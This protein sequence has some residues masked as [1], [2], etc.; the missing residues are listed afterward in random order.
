M[1]YESTLVHCCAPISVLVHFT[2]E[3][4]L[5]ASK[6]MS[7]RN[8]KTMN[9]VGRQ[10]ALPKVSSL[11][12]AARSCAASTRAVMTPDCQISKDSF[13]LFLYLPLLKPLC[14][15]Y[16]FHLF[17]MTVFSW[18]SIV[19][20]TGRRTLH[21]G[22]KNKTKKAI[23]NNTR[24]KEIYLNCTVLSKDHMEKKKLSTVL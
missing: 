11:L 13:C 18:L 8:W 23:V 10:A 6:S 3:S 19:R 14:D 5:C 12:Q 22:G 2:P 9:Y 21:F 7:N 17:Y 15:A 1:R 4:L 20:W 16:R 24:K